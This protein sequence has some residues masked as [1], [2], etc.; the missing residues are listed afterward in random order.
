MAMATV[1]IA[2]MVVVRTWRLSSRP[3]C[4][5]LLDTY[6]AV[7]CKAPNLKSKFDF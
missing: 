3:I 4:S 7:V 5:K 1:M 2:W 6:S